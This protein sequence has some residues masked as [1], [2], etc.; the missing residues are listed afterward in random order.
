M[1]GIAG[2]SWPDQALVAAMVE[3]LRHRGP[4]DEG[5]HV[6]ERVSLG[7]T[8][9]SIVDL[10]ELGHQPMAY[11]HGG[12]RVVITFNGEIFNFQEVRRALEALRYRFRSSSDTEV[13]LAAY[14]EWGV[15]C[16]HRFNGMW[17]FALYEPAARRLLL[18]RD[19]FG[20]KPLHYRLRDGRIIFA[21]EIK[22][23]LAHPIPRRARPDVVSDYLYK[24]EANGRLESFFDDIV[25]L[26]PAHNAVFDLGTGVL[27][28]SRY[29][30]PRRDNRKVVPEEFRAVL[31]KAVERRLMA[32][33][34]ISISL[35]SGTDSTAVAALTAQS[36]QAK[37]KAFSTTSEYGIG[38]ETALLAHFIDRYPQF[39]LEK[40][41]LSDASFCANYRQ[42]IWHMDEPFAR[43][44]AYVRWEVANLAQRHERKVLLNGEGA[45]EVLG[46]YA[47]FAPRFLSELLRQGSLLRF[48]REFYATLRH[49]ERDRILM[50]WR[51]MRA[52]SRGDSDEANE[53]ARALQ[54]RFELTLEPSSTKARR[55]DDVKDLLHDWVHRSSLPRLLL[56]NDKMAMANSVEGRAPFL[57]HEFVDYAFSLDSRQ[58]LVDGLRKFPLREAMRGLVPDEILF[59]RSKEAFHAPIFQYLRAE[60]IERRVREIFAE[61]RTAAYFNPR[62]YLAD[63]ERFLAQRG[64]DRLFLLHGLFLEEWARMFEVELG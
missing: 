43:Q 27:E 54:R 52:Q 34:P 35:S 39:E 63:Y 59:R 23:I 30:E 18:S 22:A 55:Y 20:E 51:E 36:T 40:S 29:Y 28:L 9:L 33:V 11:E 38:D 21:S 64:G 16:V 7:H 46:G 19:R 26:P 57:D 32:D 58:L 48:A 62:A 12:R 1:C 60:P 15:E 61:P 4:D 53:Q 42:L 8:R 49:P 56:C 37:V 3:S 6:D 44:S 2:F 24:A 13:I 10:S 45:D 41:S 17:A 5:V 25:M 50:L 14:L 31:K 47:T